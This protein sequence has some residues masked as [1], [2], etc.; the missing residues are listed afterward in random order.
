M[1]ETAPTSAPAQKQTKLAEMDRQEFLEAFNRAANLT[2][3]EEQTEAQAVIEAF[4]RLSLQAAGTARRPRRLA[5]LLKDLIFQLDAAVS[6]QLDEVVHHQ[7][8]RELEGAW[9]GLRHLVQNSELQPGVLEIKVL[10]I[11][12][13]E[14]KGMADKF[15]T[16]GGS[17]IHSPLFD[18]VGRRGLLTFGGKPFGALVGD[19]YF[20]HEDITA[21]RFVGRIAASVHAPFISSVAP[22]LFANPENP[23]EQ[24]EVTTA[25]WKA[26]R[27]MT[28]DKLLRNLNKQAGWMGLR[29]DLD[30]RYI[31]LT[32]P[33]VLARAP[34][35]G[36]S[37]VEQYVYQENLKGDS[38]NC[39]WMNTAYTSAVNVGQSFMQYGWSVNIRGEEGGGLVT[40]LP[41]A[42]M[43]GGGVI[44]PTEVVITED[45]ERTLAN[46]GFMP[47]CYYA[48]S[49]KA[50]FQSGA[51]AHKVPK[52]GGGEKGHAAAASHKL[53][54]R[55]PYTLLASR[56][57][58]CIHMM[59]R[60][61]IGSSL[62]GDELQKWLQAWLRD[63]M[64][65]N[66]E[67]APL[68]E[69]AKRPL[70]DVGTSVTV[71]PVAGEPG[72]YEVDLR[73]RPHFQLEEVNVDMKFVADQGKQ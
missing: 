11:S 30:A 42:R 57:A 50:V 54:A 44:V 65:P 23:D 8:F 69:K 66:P 6:R 68:D 37:S 64:L 70:R 73:L 39:V 47:L 9:R 16:E 12:K 20:D 22:V 21:L 71:T 61:K 18:K 34:H 28:T 52:Y 3:G 51:S 4:A 38:S 10:N 36:K 14:L 40:Q 24:K 53:S 72:V 29:D 48:D 41:T 46:E 43:E 56:F 25:G 49:D 59:L 32:F 1:A 58:Q 60:S 33:R 13:E 27:E 45:Y 17:W 31:G 2:S 62:E 7:E 15:G 55:L 67:T 19:Y 26:V 35:G 63:Y 5:A